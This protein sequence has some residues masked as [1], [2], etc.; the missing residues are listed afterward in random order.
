MT[1][2]FLIPGNWQ[3]QCIPH[4]LY[5][6][7]QCMSLHRP[8]PFRSSSPGLRGTTVITDLYFQGIP[9]NHICVLSA[10]V[11]VPSGCPSLAVLVFFLHTSLYPRI[12]SFHGYQNS[13]LLVGIQEVQE[14]GFVLKF[15]KTSVYI[16]GC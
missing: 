9:H 3:G 6:S 14:L 7:H 1:A 12:L 15:N 4:Q 5:A 2:L 16:Q 13:G 10:W 8:S 11:C